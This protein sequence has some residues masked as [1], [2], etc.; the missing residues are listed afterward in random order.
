M[1]L[2]PPARPLPRP[3]GRSLPHPPPKGGLPGEFPNHSPT[4]CTV[5]LSPCPPPP[6]PYGGSSPIRPPKGG[7]L[8]DALPGI[9]CPIYYFQVF[10]GQIFC[11][12]PLHHPLW[13]HAATYLRGSGARL[14][15]R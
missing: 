5:A 10:N 2:S 15:A 1:P 7:S 9:A 6:P 14:T 3:N 12:V 11:R 8:G 4:P 13:A